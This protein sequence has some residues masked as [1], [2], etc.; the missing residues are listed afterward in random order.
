LLVVFRLLLSEWEK[1]GNLGKHKKDQWF[2]VV[3]T[4]LSN[5]INTHSQDYQIYANLIIL[6][7]HFRKTIKPKSVKTPKSRVISTLVRASFAPPPSSTSLICLFAFPHHLSFPPFHTTTLLS[8]RSLFFSRPC[9]VLAS[10]VL[11]RQLKLQA[12]TESKSQRLKA[13]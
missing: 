8:F 12:P 2:V 11:Q 13:P 10:A 1:A 9:S 3:T 6:T 4:P 7:C 5:Q